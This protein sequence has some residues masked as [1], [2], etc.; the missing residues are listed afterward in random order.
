MKRSF[1]MPET[2]KGNDLEE[3]FNLPPL[4]V[5]GVPVKSVT[6]F[7]SGW[8]GGR[9]TNGERPRRELFFRIEVSVVESMTMGDIFV[10]ALGRILSS[11]IPGAI[12]QQGL[13]WKRRRD[14]APLCENLLLSL[15]SV[16]TDKLFLTFK[17]SIV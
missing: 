13:R 5:S 1:S 9:G 7:F 15:P 12:F 8:L 17:I 16:D 2:K 14:K 6:V 10:F 3:N 4:R 11:P